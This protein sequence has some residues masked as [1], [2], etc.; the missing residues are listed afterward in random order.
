ML[1]I[2]LAV[3]VAGSSG[4][5]TN[6]E[7]TEQVVTEAFYSLADSLGD[8]GVRS[9]AI[10]MVGDHAGNWLVEQ[11][12]RSV[13]SSSGMVVSEFS[14]S[15]GSP[16]V[17]LRLRTM[18]LAVTLG[19]AGRSW[20]FGARKVD[21][22]VRCEIAAEILDSTGVVVSAWRCGSEASDRV[23]YSELAILQGASDQE[24]LT[25]GT[26][27][28]SGG[29]ILEPIVVTGVVASL[30]YLFYSSRAE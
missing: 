1:S 7:M 17:T 26:P 22:T 18:D 30:I 14:R 25:G 2:L 29:G 4:N 20:V 12:A 23:P 16:L 6:L 21:R 5:P 28:A 27:T 24:W 15:V 13:L 8:A 19:N 11:S 10:E 3:A 9:L